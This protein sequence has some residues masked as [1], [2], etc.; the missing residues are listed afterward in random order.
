MPNVQSLKSKDRGLTL[1][2]GHWTLDLRLCEHAQRSSQD[3]LDGDRLAALLDRH[4][5]GFLR[6]R[7]LIAE[8]DERR[9]RVVAHGIFGGGRARPGLRRKLLFERRGGERGNLITKLYD[10][11]LGSLFAHSRNRSQAREIVRAD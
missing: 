9:E 4:C 1:D 2:L 7:F 8:I 3:D 10:K 11:A 5:D 6:R